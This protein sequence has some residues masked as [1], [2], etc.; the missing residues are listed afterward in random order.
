MSR[1]NTKKILRRND[2]VFSL[3][4][5]ARFEPAY[6]GF[7]DRCVNHFT[8]RPRLNDGNVSEKLRESNGGT[9]YFLHVGTRRKG[10]QKVPTHVE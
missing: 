9:V 10:G 5:V 1:K 4:A 8:T 6:R 2:G 7:A 3:E